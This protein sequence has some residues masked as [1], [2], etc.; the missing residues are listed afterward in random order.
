MLCNIS[1]T[2]PPRIPLYPCVTPL[3]P[4][5]WGVLSKS[6]PQLLTK[7]FPRNFRFFYR[8]LLYRGIF[9]QKRNSKKIFPENFQKFIRYLLYGEK[10]SR[11]QNSQKIFSRKFSLKILGTYFTGKKFI[12]IRLSKNFFPENFFYFIQLN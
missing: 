2:P 7:N 4:F 8:Y 3:L 6:T 1:V 9:Q 11:K 10:S 12:K 5:P